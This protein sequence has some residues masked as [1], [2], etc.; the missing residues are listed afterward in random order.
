MINKLN[1]KENSY[2]I[3]TCRNTNIAQ[4]HK[5]EFVFIGFNFGIPYIETIK[6]YGDVKNTS[7]DGFI[8]IEEINF[9]IDTIIKEKNLQDYKNGARKIYQNLNINNLN[10][11]IW[12]PI[13]KYEGLYS[14]SNLGRVKK[15]GKCLSGN[16]IMKQNFSHEYLVVGLTD[17]EHIRKTY[18]VHR[19][20][21]L[22]FKY[23]DNTSLEVNHING[24][25]TDNRDINLE[26]IEHAENSKHMY[27]SGNVCKK[28][29]FEDVREIQRLLCKGE[30]LQKDIAKKFNVSR[31]T[32]SEINTGKKWKNIKSMKHL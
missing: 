1:L 7:F 18:R 13:P 29:K 31:S 16:K 24:I 30:F 21:A 4:W 23:N 3:G 26:W 19:L 8:P 14:V 6:Y 28:L 10:Y 32:I 12:K 17:Y 5:G 25:K 27:T 2:Y 22:T 20:V 9:S 11:E 15:H